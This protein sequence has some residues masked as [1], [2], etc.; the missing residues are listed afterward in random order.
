MEDA[1]P[2]DKPVEI[3]MDELKAIFFVKSFMGNPDYN[4]DKN[5]PK[6]QTLYGQKVVVNF[7]DGETLVGTCNAYHLD[8]PGFFFFPIDKQSN[9]MRV[10][11]VSKF[12][13]DIS[14]VNM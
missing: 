6:D 8:Q 12:I 5:F 3:M 13:N 4:E 14:E 10:F 2:G 11:A 7:K 1:A 9:N